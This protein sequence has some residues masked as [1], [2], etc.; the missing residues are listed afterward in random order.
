[1]KR[2]C[3]PGL[4][5]GFLL[6]ACATAPPTATPIP[7]TRTA[8]LTTA[9]PSAVP[10]RTSLPSVTPARGQPTAIPTVVR[11]TLDPAKPTSTSALLALTPNVGLTPLP[12]QAAILPGGPPPLD[13][14]LP[15]GWQHGYQVLPIRD[16]LVQA[17]MNLA[18]YR[19]PAGNGTGTI[20]LLWGFPSLAPPPTKANPLSLTEVPGTPAGNLQTQML[21]ADG[22]R[23]LQGTVVDVT[24]NVGNYGQREFT[25]GGLPAVGEYFAASQCQG[26]PD[27]AGWFA[28]LNQFGGNF[29]FYVTI[30]PVEAYNNGRN[31]VQ[32]ILDSVVF[33]KPG[34]KATPSLAG[35][36]ATNTGAANR[37][38]AVPGK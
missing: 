26:E 2:Y 28:G 11:P 36:P 33:H 31:D 25:V 23:L 16:Q 24:C 9:A 38:T 20:Y 10:S 30:E 8:I 12:T 7:A 3:L 18:V 17:S 4:I 34:A 14:S 22:I 1:M 19:G 27:T 15:A 29:I 6:T 32:K 37:P 21:W 5:L 35:P 13:I